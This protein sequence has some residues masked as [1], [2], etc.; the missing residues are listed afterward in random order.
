MRGARERALERFVIAEAHKLGGLAIK[1]Q[2]PGNQGLPDR[3]VLMPGGR[4]GFL[5]LKRA[6]EKPTALQHHQMAVLGGLGFPT[7]WVDDLDGARRFLRVLKGGDE[8]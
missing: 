3:L 5:E 4:A 7:G 6:G 8:V 1:L 2:G